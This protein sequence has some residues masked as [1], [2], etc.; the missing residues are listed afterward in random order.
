MSHT[1]RNHYF[2]LIWSTKDRKNLIEKSYVN[3][4]YRYMGGIIRD[5]KGHLLEA[6]GIENHVHLLIY[7]SNLDK[8]SEIIREIKAG[9]SRWVHKTIPK[10]WDFAW[11]EGYGSFTVSKSQTE[12]VSRYIQNQEEHHKT[13]TFEEEF[14]KFL[15]VHEIE[16]DPRFVFG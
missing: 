14:I 4:L 11:Q 6:G 7:L 10:S 1:L 12:N 8:Y 3:D 13:I 15:E 16:Y 5:H 9:S 2:H